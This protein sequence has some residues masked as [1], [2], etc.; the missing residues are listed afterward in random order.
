[1]DSQT[2]FEVPSGIAPGGPPTPDPAPQPEREAEAGAGDAHEAVDSL[3]G[4]E[5]PTE[6]WHA[7]PPGLGCEPEDEARPESDGPETLSSPMPDAQAVEDIEDVDGPGAPESPSEFEA[8]PGIEAAEPPAS[9]PE[10][11]DDAR[12]TDLYEEPGGPVAEAGSGDDPDGPEQLGSLAA[13]EA[14]PAEA[15]A[16]PSGSDLGPAETAEDPAGTDG[17]DS[18]PASPSAAPRPE[19]T[20]RWAPG[21]ELSRSDSAPEAEP[22]AELGPVEGAPSDP[23]PESSDG[24]EADSTPAAGTAP[25]NGPCQA[26]A[27]RRRHKRRAV[28]EAAVIDD[29]ENHFPCVILNRSES[30]AALRLSKPEQDCPETFTLQP[31]DGPACRCKRR[32]RDG[33][34]IGVEFC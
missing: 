16:G 33:D 6:L 13:F 23:A 30:G 29:G 19:P 3:T 2:G 18:E 25:E 24:P 22:E 7:E 17:T 10:P 15:P 14:A 21:A 9:D 26:D 4:L 8:A 12:E 28:I 31:L 34:R 20:N 1:M 11:E 27:N 5:P 32:W